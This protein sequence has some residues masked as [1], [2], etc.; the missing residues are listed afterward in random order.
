M[1]YF[2]FSLD[3]GFGILIGLKLLNSNTKKNLAHA[4]GPDMRT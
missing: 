1:I 2:P 4:K 3:I